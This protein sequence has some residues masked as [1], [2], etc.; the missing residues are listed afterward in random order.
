MNINNAI[1]SAMENYQAGNLHQAIIICKK[2]VKIHPNNINAVNLLGI[3]SYEQKDYESA[4]R[5]LKKLINLNSSNAEAYY[6]LGHSLQEKGE[7]DEAITYYQKSLQLN[8]NFLD[9]Y[10]NLGTLFQDK[11][12]NDE[13]SS[14]YQ[15]ALQINPNDIDA[16]YN[17]GRVLQEKELFDDAITYYQRALQINPNLADA[18]NNI[19]TILQEKELFDEAMTYCQNALKLNPHLADAYNNIG[20]ILQEKELFD[21]AVTCFHKALQISP[22]FYK[23]YYNLGNSMQEKGQMDKAITCYQKALQLNPNDADVHFGLGVTFLLLGN[24]SQ[25]WNEYEWRWKTK[26]FHKRSCYRQP[27]DFSQPLWDGSSLKRKSILIFAEQGVGDEIMFASCFEEI[28]EQADE[29]FIECDKRLMPIF[30]R[31]FP[32]GVLIERLKEA[33]I[34]RS[35]LPQTDMVLPLG[36]LPKFLRPDFSAFP[37]KCYIVPNAD[38]VN[39]WRNRLKELDTGLKVG[40]SWRGGGISKVIRKRSIKL[41]QWAKLLSL[42]GIHFINLQYGECK[43]ELREIKEKLGITIHD[44]EDA[45]PLKDLDNFAAQIYALDLVISVDNSTVHMAGALGIPVWTLIPFLPDWR[46]ILNREDSPWYPT[47]RLFRQPTLGDWESVIAKVKNELV[48]LLGNN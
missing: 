37:Q 18:Y 38:K 35:K 31:S 36:S 3:I 23:A 15:K 5:Y 8:P 29:C 42:S 25:G 48:K 14:C 9:A 20:I 24:F 22:T 27:S 46:W 39:V 6:I 2:I 41:E 40:I 28:I 11:K 47:M 13:A 19:G 21:E 4:I 33:D 17:L 34:C 43:D 44:W 12:R 26:D 7:A 45:D 10:Y 16:L 32:K 30:T 1:K